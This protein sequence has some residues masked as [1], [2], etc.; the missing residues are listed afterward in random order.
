MKKY[1]VFVFS[2]M[3]LS[4]SAQEQISKAEKKKLKQEKAELEYQ[5]TKDIVES[6]AYTFVAL[7]AAPLGGGQ[8]FVNTIR[9]Y[10][11]VNEGEADL[12]LPYFGVVRAPNGYSPEAGIKF[13]GEL[14][15]YTISFD[16][17][18][19]EIV[20]SFEIQRGHERHEFNF[21]MYKAGAASLVVA[22]SRRNSIAYNGLITELEPPLTN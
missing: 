16:D 6:D 18:K 4:V 19:Q 9:N 12:Y 14:E 13:K 3:L 2:L 15:N 1:V 20:V 10:I 21:N 5:K 22:S 11:N 8:F 17:E 7:Q